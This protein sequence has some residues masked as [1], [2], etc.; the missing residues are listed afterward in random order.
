MV[1]IVLTV[2]RE[3]GKEYEV[4]VFDDKDVA[5]HID[6]KPC[7][8]IREDAGEASVGESIGQ[9]LSRERY[10]QDADTVVNVEGNTLRRANASI[11]AVLRGLKTL[12][13][14][15]VPCKGTGRS[16]LRPHLA[17]RIGKATS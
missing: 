5:S 17:V 9:P 12:A 3:T 11:A 7:V 1:P 8:G 14:A 16:R 13:C 4:K 2:R 10:I 15:E 6:P